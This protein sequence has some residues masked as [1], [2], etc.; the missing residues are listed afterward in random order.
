LSYVHHFERTDPR[1]GRHVHH[2]ERS[3]HYIH[4]ILHPSER[5]SVEWTRRIPILNQGNVGSCTGNALTGVLGTDSLDRTATAEVAVKADQ[6]KIFEA[7]SV[8]LDEA[9][10]DKAYQMNTRNDDCEG[11][12]LPDDTGSS[13][14]AAGKTG[15][16]LG[17]LSGY[18]HAMSMVGLESAI[19]KSAVMLGIVWYNSMFEPD[20]NGHLTVNPDSGVGGGHEIECR[21]WSKE[22]GLWLLDNSWDTSWGDNGSCYVKTKD[23]AL[24][25]SQSGDVTVPVFA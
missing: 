19:Q 5:K 7:G 15:Q 2:D 13:G 23:M 25:L 24:L 10:A 16:Q 9:F 12:Y 6:W 1:L 4:E 21:G 17:L 8:T 11:T 22:H 14:L 3:L 20:S 18:T